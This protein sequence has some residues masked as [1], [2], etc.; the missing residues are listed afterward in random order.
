MNFWDIL[1]K[2]AVACGLTV[3][4]ALLWVATIAAVSLCYDVAV[5]EWAVLVVTAFSGVGVLLVAPLLWRF[6]ERRPVRELFVFGASPWRALLLW[7]AAGIGLLAVTVAL[8]VGLDGARIV[9]CSARPDLAAAFAA[10][11]LPIAFFEEVG[12]RGFLLG[13]WR[14]AAGTRVAVAATALVFALFHCGNESMTSVAFVNVFLAGVL[15]AILR[16]RMGL[17]AATA[18]HF[19]WNAAQ[20]MA[21]FNVSGIGNPRLLLMEPSGPWWLS[22]GDFGIEGSVCAFITFGL[23]VAWISLRTRHDC[24]LIPSDEA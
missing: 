2:C 16:I 4:F 17:A 12:F 15:L 11:C 18:F 7:G 5:S 10:A 8:L 20:S 21:G 14:R 19:G 3:A 1:K 13:V 6:V 23:V 24:A 9:G 22:G